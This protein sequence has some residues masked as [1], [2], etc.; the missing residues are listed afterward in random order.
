MFNEELLELNK[1]R[2]LLRNIGFWHTLAIMSKFENFNG[3]IKLKDFYKILNNFSY[4]NAFLRIREDLVSLNLI[5]INEKPNLPN[6]I[7]LTEKGM[8]ISEILKYLNNKV[9][10]LD[11]A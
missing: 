8:K 9:F 4:Y 1:L 6:T 2:G 3:G 11:K 10:D 5:E 7:K